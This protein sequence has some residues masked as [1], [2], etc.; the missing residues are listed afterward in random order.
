M[1]IIHKLSEHI[2]SL[3]SKKPSIEVNVHELSGILSSPSHIKKINK[4][5]D[6]ELTK[7][8]EDISKNKLNSIFIAQDLAKILNVNN[9]PINVEELINL[10]KREDN[11]KAIFNLLRINNEY[12][13]TKEGL[14]RLILR[15][16]KKSHEVIE[17]LLS[18]T[19]TSKLLFKH[20]NSEH[21]LDC[22]IKCNE[23]KI[24]ELLIKNGAPINISTLHYCIEYGKFEIFNSLIKVV[25]NNLLIGKKYHELFDYAV[26]YE[27][28]DIIHIILCSIDVNLKDDKNQT[29]LHHAVKLEDLKMV[30]QFISKGAKL[31]CVD[32]NGC[33]PLN[34]AIKS[35]NVDIANLLLNVGADI[36]YTYSPSKGNI[37]QVYTEEDYEFFTPLL[38][39]RIDPLVMQKDHGTTLQQVSNTNFL[40]KRSVA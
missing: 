28:Y 23:D 4:K 7:L 35:R 29:F 34:L 8:L 30:K 31:N 27:R 20:I 25:K 10:L 5:S 26:K 16:I 6:K 2:K 18:N 1:R 21:L 39:K 11:R 40:Q 14:K 17:D 24:V 22:A 32:Q 37:I 38:S 13:T 36:R 33:T 9:Y 19:E 12:I 15:N 3:F